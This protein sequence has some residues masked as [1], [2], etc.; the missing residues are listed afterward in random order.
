[1]YGEIII[2]LGLQSHSQELYNFKGGKVIIEVYYLGWNIS[3]AV[4]FKMCHYYSKQT[5]LQTGWEIAQST[6]FS[7]DDD[8]QCYQYMN[9]EKNLHKLD[10]CPFYPDL[11]RYF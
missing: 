2:K 9:W 10:L 3:Y 5:L 8:N 6:F 1:M 7:A 11:L 4:V